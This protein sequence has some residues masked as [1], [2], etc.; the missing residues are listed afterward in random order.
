MFIEQR[1]LFNS[2]MRDGL[3]FFSIILSCI[4]GY[5]VI[6]VSKCSNK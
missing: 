3:F 4:I 6:S 2:N 5:S 1:S